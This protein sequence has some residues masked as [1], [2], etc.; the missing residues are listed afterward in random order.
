MSTL[1][2]PFWVWAAT[3][4]GLVLAVT[5]ELI[6]AARR[7]AREPSMRESA[8]WTAGVV[9]LA[10]V[11]GLS[12][13]WLGHPG[14]AGQFFAGW[15][16]EYS[17]SL[18]NLFIFVLLIGSAAVPKELHS[19]ILLLGVVMALMLRGIFIA[20]GATAINRFSWVLYIFG[21]LLIGT[22][23]RLVLT[24]KGHS[25]GTPRDS[26]AL[27]AVRRV[28]P[29]SQHS[30]GTRLLTEVNGR[31]MATPV[32]LLIVAIAA[33]DLAFALD[34]IP[35]IFGLTRDPYLVFTANMFALLG[36][37]HLYF[38]IGGLL[39]RLAH[40]TAGLA[41][42]LGFIGFKLI[43]EALIESGVHHVG[44]VPVPHIGIGVSLGVI[45]GVLAVVTVTSLLSGRNHKLQAGDAAQVE[46][47]PVDAADHPERDLAACRASG[48]H[49]GS[50]RVDHGLP[51]GTAGPA[52]GALADRRRHVNGEQLAKRAA[53]DVP[54]QVRG[55]A[56][57]P[58]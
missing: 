45:G 25:G 12:I 26:L 51:E 32:L 50:I 22:A 2:V 27:R 15:L 34:S 16:T 3:I 17:L 6:L 20:V 42:I 7:G 53:E 58:S 41:V 44:P 24:R 33:T 23:L 55:H 56:L 36:L 35:A 14:A 48:D 1:A 39:S 46:P 8:L 37:R 49:A 40:L 28:V 18:D 57:P 4:G 11:F 19:R 30:D 13:A 10:V 43:A 9:A 5:A 38:L 54:V 31:R 21:V 29:V 52:R 47:G